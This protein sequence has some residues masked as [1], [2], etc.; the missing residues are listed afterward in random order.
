MMALHMEHGHWLSTYQMNICITPLT[1]V[2]EAA[3]DAFNWWCFVGC[4]VSPAAKR[5]HDVLSDH[6]L[7]CSF[8]AVA[9]HWCLV[10]FCLLLSDTVIAM[11]Q[12]QCSGVKQDMPMRPRCLSADTQRCSKIADAEAAVLTHNVWYIGLQQVVSVALCDV[13]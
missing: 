8:D 5:L 11:R 13:T 7:R 2:V 1:T 3:F 10:V 6:S 12:Q 4:V 9:V